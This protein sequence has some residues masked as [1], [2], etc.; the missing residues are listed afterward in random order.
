MVLLNI[1]IHELFLTFL[2]M[3]LVVLLLIVAVLLYSFSRYRELLH[4]SNWSRIID[5]KVSEVIVF[6]KEENATDGELKQVSANP[7]FRELFLEK[8][9]GSEKKFS[10]TAQEEIKDLFHAYNL[11]KEAFSKLSQ[12]KAYL[13]AG[14]IQE[15]TSMKVEAAVPRITA[16]L[17]HPSP[18]VYQEAQYAM[19]AF[20]GFEGLRFLDTET[21][22]ISDWQQ[23][24]LLNSVTAI[25][26]NCEQE[27]NG[28]LRSS[29][30]SVIIFTLSLLR[31]FQMLSFYDAVWHLL[32]HPSTEVRIRAV[33]TL[34]SL[35]NDQTMPALAVSFPEQPLEVQ[36][37]ILRVMEISRDRRSVGFLKQQLL[38]HPASGI[39]IQ[40]AE[41]LF[42][43]GHQEYL[44]Q[45]SC[46]PESSEELI[47]IIK[48]ALQEKIC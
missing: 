5:K 2:G 37:E 28:W 34:L 35:E 26:E 4:I 39:R 15:L 29:N 38:E 25:P 44:N 10:G 30:D 6:G 16:L 9:V 45:V 1:T 46:N 47:H 13:I 32:D 17:S 42:T 48:H 12:K 11:E 8:L 43:L 19:V 36:L 18:A 41:A 22:K 3:L 31:K 20:K 7:S 33:Q 21:H 24:R 14:G 27:V 23:L 40:A